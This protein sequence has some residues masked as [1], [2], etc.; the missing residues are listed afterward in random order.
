MSTAKWKCNL[1]MAA[2]YVQNRGNVLVEK[3]KKLAF[4]N[5]EHPLSDRVAETG[6]VLV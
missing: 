5:G 3:S 4:L 1:T 2:A 6:G